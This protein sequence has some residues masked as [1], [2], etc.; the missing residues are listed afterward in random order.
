MQIRDALA[1]LARQQEGRPL[2]ET[3]DLL[4]FHASQ[5]FGA[6]VRVTASAVN[7]TAP[8]TLADMAKLVACATGDKLSVREACLAIRSRTPE[9]GEAIAIGRIFARLYPITKRGPTSIY[10]IAE[11][12]RRTLLDAG[13]AEA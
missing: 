7:E 1:A 12:D 3:C 5:V 10:A 6:K 4:A 13:V 2:K 11:R 9:H 8:L